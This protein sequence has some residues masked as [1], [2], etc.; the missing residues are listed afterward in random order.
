MHNWLMYLY[1]IAKICKLK[2]EHNGRNPGSRKGNKGKRLE[3]FK[4]TIVWFDCLKAAFATSSGVT[5][6]SAVAGG[7][8]DPMT[9]THGPQMPQGCPNL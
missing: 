8:N 7:S 2:R 9:H 3:I 1:R 4:M 6:T 5:A